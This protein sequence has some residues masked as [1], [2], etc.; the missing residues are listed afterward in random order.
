[1]KSP[2]KISLLFVSATLVLPSF[3]V[4]QAVSVQA[5]KQILDAPARGSQA[6]ENLGTNLAK[7]ASI[8]KKSQADLSNLLSNDSSFWLD[9]CGYAFYVDE[10]ANTKESTSI[11]QA[12][13]IAYDQTFKLH[14]KPGSSR[15]IYLDFNGH[16]FSNT[17]WN[18]YFRVKSSYFANGYS[19]DT[20]F[21]NFTNL[22]QDVIQSIWLRVSEDY[23]PFDVDVTTEEPAAGVLE[24]SSVSDSVYGTRAVVTGDTGMQRVCGCGGVA[25]VGV[26][27]NTGSQWAYYQ[28]AWI[29]TAGVG[30][31]AKNITEALSHEVGHNLGLSHDGTRSV[32]YYQ[33]ASGWAPIMGVGYYQGLT[34][35]SK[36]EY[37]GANNKEDD[38]VVMSSNGAAI[39]FDDYGD[40][41][42]SATTLQ[43]LQNGVISSRSDTDWFTLTAAASSNVTLSANVES[44]S[45]NLDIKME[46]YDAANLTTPL[47][48]VD[49]SMSVVNGDS[50]SGLSAS[51][52]I[53]FVAGRTYFVKIDGVGFGDPA[54]TGYSDYGSIGK[55]SIAVS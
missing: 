29:F 42:T 21:N 37:P 12:A 55:Y 6:L 11:V 39:R 1:M 15:T 26:F 51:I 27:D 14:S 10:T 25:Y 20:N 24:R 3:Q 47:A 33:G 41:S 19:Q 52:T 22:E 50:V 23:A 17:A 54:T 45:P 9:E 16:S 2:L 30:T 13:T 28:P 35:W 44:V 34:Q 18:K 5:C 32:G 40:S 53:A 31:G 46:I 4:S 43:P 38:F 48:T 8:N 7:V 49:P 36:G